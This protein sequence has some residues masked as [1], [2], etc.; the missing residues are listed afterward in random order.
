MTTEIQKTKKT[1]TLIEALRSESYGFYN[2]VT[3]K[4]ITSY[5]MKAQIEPVLSMLRNYEDI[6]TAFIEWNIGEQEF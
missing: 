4:L 3:G 2:V 1:L 5:D 6:Q